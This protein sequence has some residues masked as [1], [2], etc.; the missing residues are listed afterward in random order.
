[1]ATTNVLKIAF[2]GSKSVKSNPLYQYDYGQ[3]ILFVG[4]SLPNVYE[5][6]F[7]N[8]DETGESKT[9]L[10]DETGAIIP[11]EYLTTGL[12]VYAWIFLHADTSDGET[13][14]KVRIPVNK[15]ARPSDTEPTPV[16]QDIITQA[17]A[18]LNQA[19][20]DTAESA[21]IASDASN[22]AIEFAGQARESARQANEYKLSAVESANNAEVSK[23]GAKQFSESARQSAISASNSAIEASDFADNASASADRAEQSAAQS[24]YMFFSIDERGHLIYEK[25]ENVD[26][27]FYLRDGHLYV[28]AVA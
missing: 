18:V 10:G 19:V 15:R 11:D 17:I 4:L 14:Y 8:Y 20:V 22:V 16:Q 12:D 9:S 24:G 2:G 27:D 13:K 3:K 26:V 6:H 28:E 1:M 5:V 21:E 7:S 23:Q 25:T